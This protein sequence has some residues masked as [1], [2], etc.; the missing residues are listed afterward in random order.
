M[1]AISTDTKFDIIICNPPYV[2]EEEMK[3][4]PREVAA[5]EPG[6][7]L[8]G[9]ANGLDFYRLVLPQAAA[10][11]SHGGRLIMEIGEGQHEEVAKIARKAGFSL[12]PNFFKDL[13]GVIR[14]VEFE[15]P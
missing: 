4:L 7:A 10:R 5:F 12:N 6:I 9:G 15:K 8:R 13:A 3:K 11:L 1:E 14:V 2:S